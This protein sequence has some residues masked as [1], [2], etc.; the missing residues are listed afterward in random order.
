MI[1]WA[2]VMLCAGQVALAAGLAYVSRGVR[3]LADALTQITG[4]T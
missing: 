4:P 2:V 3:Q 1:G